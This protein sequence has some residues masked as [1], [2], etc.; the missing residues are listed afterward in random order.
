MQESDGVG[1]LKRHAFATFSVICLYD[2]TWHSVK[3]ISFILRFR[4]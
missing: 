1:A 3:D 2:A 4:W